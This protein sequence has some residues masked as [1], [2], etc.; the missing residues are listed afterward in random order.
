MTFIPFT[1]QKL[2]T[3]KVDFKNRTGVGGGF[4]NLILKGDTEASASP[5]SP[6]P[7]PQPPTQVVSPPSSTTPPSNDDAATVVI[8][9]GKAKKEKK[10]KSNNG[11]GIGRRRKA[12]ALAGEDGKSSVVLDAVFGKSGSSR[13]DSA[14][15]KAALDE[16]A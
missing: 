9:K 12:A 8:G 16:E 11:E 10:E 2:V 1:D 5:P 14:Q 7:S 15:V 3:Q 4:Q 6:T 13:D